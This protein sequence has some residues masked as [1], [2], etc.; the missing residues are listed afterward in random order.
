MTDHS[1]NHRYNNGYIYG[2]TLFRQNVEI[3]NSP[4]FKVSWYTVRYNLIN[5]TI[6]AQGVI[7]CNIPYERKF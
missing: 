1:S 5:Q 3:E 7:V 4:N 2:Q 6:S